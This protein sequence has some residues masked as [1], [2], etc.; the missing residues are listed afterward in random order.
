M[1]VGILSLLAGPRE[2]ALQC[3]PSPGLGVP[4]PFVMA[5]TPPSAP[6]ESPGFCPRPSSA[7]ASL[8]SREARYRARPRPCGSGRGARWGIAP[9]PKARPKGAW[10]RQ[11]P[12]PHPWGPLTAA[13]GGRCP[14]GGVGSQGREWHK[15]QAR[16][17]MFSLKNRHQHSAAGHCR[18]PRRR[19]WGLWD[20]V[21]GRGSAW[22]GGWGRVG[23]A[24]GAA[25]GGSRCCDDQWMMNHTTGSTS[26]TTIRLC[27][28][29]GQAG[30]RAAV[31]KRRDDARPKLD[32]RVWGPELPRHAGAADASA[33]KATLGRGFGDAPCSLRSSADPALGPEPR[34][35]RAGGKLGPASVHP[36][37]RI[38]FEGGAAPSAR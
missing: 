33:T 1:R 3:S 2:A 10:G 9:P 8:P 16:P 37:P 21:E 31:G 34:R 36:A 25:A 23:R 11:A 20:G 24:V 27:S 28:A 13:R 30:S 32:P 22:S 12:R 6:K 7:E 38:W 35:A 29:R 15:A 5:L 19:W 14:A 17:G 26:S 18:T 4:P